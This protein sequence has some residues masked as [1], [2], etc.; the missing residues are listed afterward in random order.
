MPLRLNVGVN[1]K[2]GLPN[3]SSLGTSCHVEVEVDS[4]LIF[5]DLDAFHQKVSQAYI[6]CAQAVNDELARQQEAGG[7]QNGP[8]RSAT[9]L[10]FQDVEQIMQ[11]CR[12]DARNTA[13]GVRLSVSPTVSRDGGW[14]GDPPPHQDEGSQD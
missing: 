2:I 12:D 9:R 4:G 11:S 1:K 7:Q 5:D 10:R 6:A 14:L 3:Y 13:N 8:S